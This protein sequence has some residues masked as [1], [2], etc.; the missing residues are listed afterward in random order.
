[1]AKKI[2]KKSNKVGKNEKKNEK[3]QEIKDMIERG[4]TLGEAFIGIMSLTATNWHEMG[5]AAIGLAKAWA[6][7]KIIADFADVEVED[8]FESQL[9]YYEERFGRIAQEEF[10]K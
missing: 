10:G 9:A 7:L 3:L 4:E 8:L 1:M 6:S 5:A 2:F